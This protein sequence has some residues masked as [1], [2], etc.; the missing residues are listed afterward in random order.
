MTTRTGT[1]TKEQEKVKDVQTEQEH[2]RAKAE[3][4]Q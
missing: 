3:Q 2:P 1:T 4:G